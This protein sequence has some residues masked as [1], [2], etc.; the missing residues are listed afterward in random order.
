MS[1]SREEARFETDAAAGRIVECCL[2][3]HWVKTNTIELC[4]ACEENPICPRCFKDIELCPT[5][6]QVED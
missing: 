4:V 6:T 5:C 2:C 3:H 1:M